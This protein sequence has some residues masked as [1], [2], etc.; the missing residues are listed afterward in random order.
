MTFFVFFRETPFTLPDSVGF[1]GEIG[2]GT[3]NTDTARFFK[4][5]IEMQE[6]ASKVRGIDSVYYIF[7][8]IDN[9]RKI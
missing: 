5:F 4:N 9:F 2:S 3:R 7:V 1:Q 8:M 6:V